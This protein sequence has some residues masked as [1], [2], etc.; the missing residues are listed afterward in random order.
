MIELQQSVIEKILKIKLLVCDVDGTMTDS[1]MYYTETGEVAKKFNTHD[2]MGIVLLNKS[3]IKTAIITSENSNIVRARAK[4]LGIEH[5]I[6]GSRNKVE[7]LKVLAQKL[8]LNLNE[9]AY[10]GDDVNDLQS[11]EISG[12]SACP[13]DSTKE[14]LKISN[15]ICKSDG[16]KGAVRELADLILEIQNKPNTL[17][18][19][20]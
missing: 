17:P 1:G 12:F 10:I 11:M 5:V 18:E 15:Y 13:N 9:I 3:G 7:S 20:W 8:Q 14:I 4:K 2:G 6:L 16:G 19:S